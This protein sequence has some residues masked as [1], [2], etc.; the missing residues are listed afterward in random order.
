MMDA[1]NDP[2]VKDIVVMS[3]AQVGKTELLLN[4][5]GY[6]IG[7]DPAPI[8]LVQPT[9]ENA[10]AFSK[11]RLAPMLRDTPVLK[12][13]V[14]DARSRDSNNTITH[15]TFAGGHITMV[16]ANSPVGL[17]SRPI[18]IVLCDETDRYPLSSGGEGDPVDL[19]RKRATTFW[20][21]KVILV[22]TPVTKGASIIEEAYQASD[23]RKFYVPCPE[24]GHEQILTWSN[25]H[26][27]ENKPEEAEYSCESC[28]VLWDDADR[29][30]AVKAGKWVAERPDAIVAGFW[31]NAIYS[32]WVELGA[33][34]KDFLRAK[35][36]PGKLQTFVNTVLAETWE[37]VGSRLDASKVTSRLEPVNTGQIH[38][39]ILV[40]TAGA[41][42]QQ[43]RIEVEV[44]G[45]AADEQSW[46]LDY[47]VILGD[48]SGDAIWDEL[49]EVLRDVY[50]TADGRHLRIQSAAV[51]SGFMTSKV[52]AFTKTRQG[53]NAIKGQSG[54]GRPLSSGASKTRTGDRVFI[55]GVDTAK[56]LVFARAARDD[57]GPGYMHFPE[58]RSEEYFA[59][60]LESEEIIQTRQRGRLAP[61]YKQIRTRNEALDCRVYAI[62]ALHIGRFNLARL[63]KRKAYNVVTVPTAEPEE[64]PTSVAAI[65]R[66][67]QP[68]RQKPQN[69]VSGWR[70]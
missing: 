17:A 38:E 20:N 36:N 48:P 62:A 30:R 29:N 70:S 10:E 9:K 24:C 16:G 46:S 59:Q 7:H 45:W 55:I 2:N 41:D 67:R 57:V 53:V 44:V 3:S 69:W 61:S 65:K 26:W 21:R 32:P 1:V 68:R 13:K 27:P 31:I 19:A 54:A 11:D 47:H 28:G 18:R 63:E 64:S 42:V 56:D 37:E 66:M 35:D 5:I 34:A 23:Q 14:A 4:T 60:L 25:V 51:D 49:D 39:D 8:L 6:H 33:L 50:E 22:S 52:Y 43:D 58:D 15:K 40:I 12:G